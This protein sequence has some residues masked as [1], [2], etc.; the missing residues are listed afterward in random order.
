VDHIAP[1]GAAEPWDRVG[2]LVGDRAARASRVAVALDPTVDVIKAAL[3]QSAD[4][5]VTHHPIHLAPIESLAAGD[6]VADRVTAA[7]RGGIAVIA[8]HT[9]AD[10]VPALAT[11]EPARA[12]GMAGDRQTLV[13]ASAKGFLKV[14]V[15]V[16]EAAADDVARAMAEAGAGHIGDYSDCTF[17]ASGT[18][19]FRPLEGAEP[20]IGTIGELERVAEMRVE[21]VVE[22]PRLAKVLAAMIEAHP[23][24]EVAYDVYALERTGGGGMG[25]VGGLATPLGLDDLAARCLQ[26]FGVDPHFP[27]GIPKDRTVDRVAIMPGSASGAGDAA[28][29]ARAQALV[30]GEMKY[31]EALD[32]Q[33]RGVAVLA[34]GHAPS[35]Q[36]IAR[37]LAGALAEE[38]QARGWAIQVT[39]AGP[40]K[41]S[42]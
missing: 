5:L 22:G 33:D 9:N 38:V 15:F 39:Q 13:R 30:C 34:V 16:P 17:M 23:Y 35:E 20:F 4:V 37:A 2:L 3:A 7:L 8:A 10:V 41:G 32:A 18:G 19:T 28:V 25:C 12:F 14:V 42:G 36:H 29:C 40:S 6:P 26:A 31:H 21:T 11:E 27:A 1:F 24:E